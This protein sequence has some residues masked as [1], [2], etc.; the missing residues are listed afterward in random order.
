MNGLDIT[1]IITGRLNIRPFTDEELEIIKKF[2]ER[3][4][5]M[6]EPNFMPISDEEMEKMEQAMPHMIPV[7]KDV[8]GYTDVWECPCCEK[9]VHFGTASKSYE[10]EFCPNCGNY[11][12]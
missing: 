4:T 8:R 10:Y 6:N 11:V 5:T 12:L 7:D 3:R 1:P 2:F 9:R